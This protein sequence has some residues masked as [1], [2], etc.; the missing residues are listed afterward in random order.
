VDKAGGTVE[1]G[2]AAVV[3]VV[4]PGMSFWW[5]WVA[6]NSLA[7]LV[8]LGSTALLFIAIAP[9]IDGASLGVALAYAGVVAVGGALFEG[10]SVG[11]AQW[12]VLRTA[13]PALRLRPWVVATS[14]GAFVAWALGMLPS[15]LLSA[16]GAASGRAPDLGGVA[17]YIAAAGMGVVLGPMLGVPQ[18]L[19]LVRHRVRARWWV[20]ANSLAWAVGMPIVFVGAGSVSQDAGL[21][22]IVGWVVVTLLAAGAAVGAVNGA[23]LVWTL[24]RAAER[25]EE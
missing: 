12:F 14:L 13:L 15:T 5:R 6:A 9:R 3:D 11:Y 16:G 4:R 2:S 8:G 7:E 21:A 17:M 10:V 25:V 24:R 20:L 23:V 22:S 1:A 19:V 18:A